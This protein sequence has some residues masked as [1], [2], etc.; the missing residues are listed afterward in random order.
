[1]KFGFRSTADRFTSGHVKI[2]W[3]THDEVLNKVAKEFMEAE[4]LLRVEIETTS[5]KQDE[6]ANF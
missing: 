5:G 3:H 1:M 4:E 2:M 6:F